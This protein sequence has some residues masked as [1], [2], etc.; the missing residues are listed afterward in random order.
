[1]VIPTEEEAG[2]VRDLATRTWL[3]GDTLL[4]TAGCG[5]I[6]NERFRVPGLD[7]EGNERPVGGR[8]ADGF[9]DAV[10]PDDSVAGHSVAVTGPH[11]TCLAVGCYRA[12]RQRNA[13]LVV[14]SHRVAV[15]RLRDL[16]GDTGDAMKEFSASLHEPESV[17]GVQGLR[18]FGKFLKNTA[19]EAV[20]E[21]RRP[22]LTKRPQDAALVAEFEVG[23][24]EL[25]R[26]DRW[27]PT[28]VPNLQHGPRHLQLHF[29]DGS[30]A[31]LQTDVAGAIAMAGPETA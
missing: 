3:R 22:P 14:T 31:R 16:Q 19:V 7:A 2:L 23:R 18:Q 8:I 5:P 13:W 29:G 17:R 1:M 6:D 12:A 20:R 26:I 4:A 10:L 27:K 30:W 21:V 28:L 24:A 15:L 11:A 9:M 25:V